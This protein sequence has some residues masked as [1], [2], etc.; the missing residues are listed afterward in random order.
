MI[1]QTSFLAHFDFLKNLPNLAIIFFLFLLFSRAKSMKTVLLGAGFLGLLLDI[2]TEK[3]I[4][5]YLS[6]FLLISL[7]AKF[8]LKKYVN[9]PF[10]KTH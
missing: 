10:A 9:F 4:G 8:G 5:F 2:F 3:P 7:L 6:L 1:F